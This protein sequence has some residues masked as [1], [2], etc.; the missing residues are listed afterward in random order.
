MIFLLDVFFPFWKYAC[1]EKKS[2]KGILES[3]SFEKMKEWAYR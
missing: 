3:C 1:E 2:V